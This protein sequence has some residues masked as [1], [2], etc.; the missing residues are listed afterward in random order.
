MPMS[1][2]PRLESNQQLTLRRHLI[3]PLI[4]GDERRHYIHQL[5]P[6]DAERY[7]DTFKITG[8]K[9]RKQCSREIF[10]AKKYC[11]IE[12]LI[13]LFDENPALGHMDT[14]HLISLAYV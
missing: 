12:S 5:S 14:Q 1:W 10:Q 4:D 7:T 8:F 2:R 13:R 9:S 6:P 3:Y 11:S